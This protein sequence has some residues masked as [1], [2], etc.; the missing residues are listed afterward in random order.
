VL[1]ELGGYDPEIFVWANELEFMLRFFDRG[2][3]H[4]H[5]PEV[6]AVHIRDVSG[7]WSDYVRSLAYQRNARHWAYIAAK[8]L[9]ARHALAVLVAIL[10]VRL[11]D[12]VSVDWRALKAIPQALAGFATGLRRRD[13]VRPELS[14]AYRMNLESFASPWWFARPPR[15]L[16]RALPRELARAAT[17]RATDEPPP[18]D[19]R[20][21]YDERSRYYPRSAATLEF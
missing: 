12:G 15:E 20:G 1:R 18:D 21:Y 17:G 11:R 13:P 14:R 2:Y 6:S 16:A 7:H 9:R 19:R 3:R 8:Q 5:L 4:L 10:T